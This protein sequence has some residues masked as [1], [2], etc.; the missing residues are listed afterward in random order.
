MLHLPD[1]NNVCYSCYSPTRFEGQVEIYNIYGEHV[2]TYDL[3][4][5]TLPKNKKILTLQCLAFS[6]IPTIDLKYKPNIGIY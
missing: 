2:Y 4:M 6:V 3:A 5:I 1:L